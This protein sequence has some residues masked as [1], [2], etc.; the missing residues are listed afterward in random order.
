MSSKQKYIMVNIREKVQDFIGRH[1]VLFQNFTYISFLQIFLLAAPL[2]TYPY[3]IRVLGKELY[4]LVIT[5]QV[6]AS[7]CSI[8]VRF[9]FDNVS[10]KHVSIARD[11]KNKLSEIFSS[12]QTVR[13]ILWILSFFVY[14]GIILLVPIYKENFF[15][16]LLSF[17]ATFNELL[18]PQF[19]FQGIEKMKYTSILNI[20]IRSI[21]ILLIFLCVKR[22]EDYLLVPLLNS[23]G[24]LIG[25]V[26]SLYIIIHKE[27][28][29]LKR[30]QFSTMTFY[31]KD[32]FSIF[33]TDMVTSIKDKFNYLLVGS[34]LGMGE[35]VIYDLGSKFTNVL[36]KPGTIV[37]TVLFPKM[38][39]EKNI[40]LFKK[41]AVLSF[42]VTLGL[43][44]ILNIFCLMS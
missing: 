26:I 14:V 4:G 35:V 20:I 1:S 41:A 13:L 21:F 16:F 24:Y 39:K 34:F 2:I 25:G 5:A 36:V 32:A 28:I 27:R 12:V 42:F 18:F 6:V 9:G 30:P 43:V 8:I 22:P 7:Y 37:G 38:A 44:L 23:I 40:R 10:A 31:T 17:G 33:A 11:D 3:L 29:V 15:L 19:I